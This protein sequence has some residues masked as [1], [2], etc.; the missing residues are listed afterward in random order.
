MI[1]RHLGLYAIIDYNP[2]NIFILL[3]SRKLLML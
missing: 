2:N 1:S 3:P